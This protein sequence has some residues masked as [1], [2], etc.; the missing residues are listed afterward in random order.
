MAKV[1]QDWVAGCRDC[2]SRKV[3]PRRVKPPLR[4]LHVG[5]VG[6]RWA[7]DFAGQLPA[8]SRGNRYAVA[9]TEY[10]TKWVILVPVSTR[11]ADDL[12]AEYELARTTVGHLEAILQLSLHTCDRI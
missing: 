1:V 4:S 9:F 11:A 3:R 5:E 6:D 8:T 7:M 2:G 10:L 12:D